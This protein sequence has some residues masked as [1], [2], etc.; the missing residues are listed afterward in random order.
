M[1]LIVDSQQSQAFQNIPKMFGQP[2]VG[3]FS[4]VSL[5]SAFED[6]QDCNGKLFTLF[7]TTP[8]FGF[9]A[10]CGVTDLCAEVFY[11]AQQL[12]RVIFTDIAKA[13]YRSKNIDQVFLQFGHDDFLRIFLIRYV[14]C[15][16]AFRLHRA[17]KVR[18]LFKMSE[19]N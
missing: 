6:T 3:L 13:F 8:L 5:P 19:I 11:K 2:F 10:I 12:L 14:F 17:F 7:L 9:C 15:Y 16:Y 18:N 1:F 4:P